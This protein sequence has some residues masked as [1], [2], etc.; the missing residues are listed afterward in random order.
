MKQ[1]KWSEYAKYLVLSDKS[2]GKLKGNFSSYHEFKVVQDIINRISLSDKSNYLHDG[3]IYNRKITTTDAKN[4]INN[5]REC[6]W[7]DKTALMLVIANQIKL[8]I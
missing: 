6:K 1:E 8:R 4:I 3:N 7:N 2:S 5:V